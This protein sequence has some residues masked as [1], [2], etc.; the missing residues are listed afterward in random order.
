MADDLAVSAGK[1]RQ[2]AQARDAHGRWAQLALD[3]PDTLYDPAE[4]RVYR[5]LRP[6]ETCAPH[7]RLRRD[8][9]VLYVLDLSSP[10]AVGPEPVTHRA[11]ALGLAAIT[12]AALSYAI[13]CW[14][15]THGI[16]AWDR[17][18][19][20]VLVYFGCIG[21]LGTARLVSWL[22]Q[23]PGPRPTFET[24]DDIAEA[25][26]WKPPEYGSSGRELK[27]KKGDDDESP[28]D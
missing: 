11:F 28:G 16:H 8:R 7:T 13:A 9:G 19:V 1:R 26:K 15:D 22:W 23:P 18:S 17:I 27:P 2:A 25:K 10:L 4:R 21:W 5:L 20:A 3:R 6:G 12:D 24:I 14:L